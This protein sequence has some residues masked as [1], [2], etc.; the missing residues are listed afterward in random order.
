MARAE[1]DRLRAK[2]AEYEKERIKNDSP[3]VHSR[4]W[5]P[6]EH[7]RFLEALKK[8]GPKDVRAIATYVGTRN[9]TQVRTHAQKY[10][11]RMAREAKQEH[12]LQSARKR[13]MSESD[14]ARVGRSVSTPPGSPTMRDANPNPPLFSTTNWTPDAQM[15]PADP[16]PHKTTTSQPHPQPTPL[17]PPSSF[18]NSHPGPNSM[19]KT[20]SPVTPPPSAQTPQNLHKA[21]AFPSNVA[22]PK[23]MVPE[24]VASANKPPVAGA[25]LS[26]NTGINLLSM[27]ATER[28]MEADKDVA[29][30]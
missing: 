2:L 17:P 30:R 9:A 22:A 20:P 15:T 13:S 24:P 7:K 23:P 11:L 28:K 18:A 8:F 6:P 21:P 27:V 16:S 5:T 10:F 29:P 26:D 3:K 14:L 4:Y 19:Q 25:K 12:A 1:L